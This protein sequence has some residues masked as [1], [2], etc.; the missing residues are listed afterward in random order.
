MNRSSIRRG[1]VCFGM[2]LL[3]GTLRTS[4]ATWFVATNGSDA[5]GTGAIGAPLRTLN[6]ALQ[7]A[8]SG[9]VVE[10]RGGT[11]REAEEVRF[12]RPG[13]TMRSYAG[14]WAAIA[15]PVDD[16]DD[17]SV[18]VLIDPDADGTT[19][20]RLEISGGYY[21]GVMLQTKW[22]WGDPDDRAGAGNVVIEDCVIHDTGRDAIKITP[23]CD[24]VLIRR[25]EI[26]N[27]GVGPANA[28][29]ENAEGIDCVNGDR[30]MVRDCSIHDVF[31][32]G[33]Y[34]KGGSAD[35]VVERTRVSRCGG[36]GILLG[37]DTSPEYF[38][39]AANPRYYENVRGTVRNCLVRETGWEGIGMYAA[40][41]PAVFNNTL[42]DVCTGNVHAAIYFGLSYQDWE[43]HPG[44]PPSVNA[45]ILNNLVAQPAGFSDETFEIRYSS[46]LGGMSALSG[47]PAMDHNGYFIAAGG[48][49]RF[50][51]R[52]PGSLLE[53][54]T[55]AQWR[56]HAGTD[57]QSRT[58]D[59]LFADEADGALWVASPY[60][61][62]GTNFA[63]MAGA[64][65]LVG[66][67]RLQGGAVD[68]G[69]RESTSAGA[70][71]LVIGHAALASATNVPAD[72]RAKIVQL[73]W[74]FT[75]ASVGG[76]LVTG[77]NVLW[78]SDPVRFPIQIY[79]YD[80]DNGD[81]AYHGGVATEGS[82]G[83]ADYRASASPAGTSGG[84]VY[85]CQRGNPDWRNKMTCFSNSIVQ[86]GWRY[87]KANVVLDKLCWIDPDADPAV[88]CARMAALESR[89]PQT[90]F[91][92]MTMPL[93]T[94][95]A[96]SE[97]D[98]RNAF[99]RHVRTYCRTAG[100]WLLD[101]ADIEAWTEA[102]A[103]QK[104]V[105]G[106]VTNQR[107]VAAYAVDAGGFD[108]H[109]NATGRRRA[110]LGW[111]ALAR[112][113]FE[114]DRDSDG[115]CDG[116][117]LLA[118]TCPTNALE[119]VAD[120]AIAPSLRTHSRAAAAGQ[121]IAVTANV[122]WAAATN[123]PWLSITAGDAG[124]GNGTVT[125][126]VAGNAG[127]FRSG[128]IT[129]SGGGIVRTC[130]VNQLSALPMPD[131]PSDFDGD[132][133][134]DVA[135]F[136]AAGG[137]WNFLYGAGG[138]GSAAFGWSAVKPVPADYDG[139][140]Q[141]DLAV[142]HPASGNWYVRPSGGGAD[143]V[144]AFG[145]SATIPLPGDYDGDG[146]ADLAVFHRATARWYFRYSAGGPDAGVAY[147]WSAVLPV[148][149]D[150]DGD[151]VVDLAVY[152][153]AS[154]T[155]YVHES[156]SGEVVA[157]QLGGG[158]ALPVPA[159]YDGDGAAD[160]AVFTRA[161]ARW[162]VAYSG[163]GSLAMAFGWSAVL[164]VPADYDGDGAADLAVYHPAGG[165]W[166]VRQSSDLATAVKTLGGPGQNPVLR[167]S[168]IHS[169]FKLL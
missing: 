118:G 37:F 14:E 21:Y 160:V 13:V 155:W 104:Y 49:P 93:T 71:S 127:G 17:F 120:L 101:L 79:D 121:T 107:M 116:D 129:I 60:V 100:K 162:Q 88:Y 102:G 78:E 28:S 43:P 95:T 47:W 52:R 8:T 34:L 50:T 163:G 99:N 112:A 4:A 41:N 3:A 33:I 31:S 146:L 169:W 110:A 139:D 74:F 22:D 46:D 81:G 39:V 29:A 25:C 53:E 137:R 5:V 98:Q 119:T 106:G 85:E 61:D 128:R 86:S 62:R 68:V 6:F 147:G 123:V 164:P 69:A 76:N 141:T 12:R 90:L 70:N 83:G 149:A 154:G 2:A 97:N 80:G 134:A 72:L 111:Y 66:N 153:P 87:P 131:V 126:A 115:A 58:N 168:L 151:G 133:A 140:G 113:L 1:A 51:D 125:Y 54:G 45:T 92:Y 26:Y 165:K 75:H 108:F 32:T 73:R 64:A 67:P 27:T 7:Q 130:T 161:T 135:T 24:D 55:L 57:A 16:E 59:P 38:D 167:N 144:E 145:W 48:V 124:T 157:K 11:Y 42:V 94:E 96:G 19:L 36:G 63:W 142:Y 82:E 158:K 117:E 138:S 156:S 89:F 132:G 105:S 30:I 152:H 10:V 159:D 20:S 109:L 122:A 91:V 148:P 18:C 23:N 9:D 166:Y 114:V 56:A 44:R 136:Q 15:A 150:Y 35:C 103:E 40:S 65:D 84:F 143:R 77:L